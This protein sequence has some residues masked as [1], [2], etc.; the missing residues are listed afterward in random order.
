MEQCSAC[1]NKVPNLVEHLKKSK[2]C[3]EKVERDKVSSDF[4]RDKNGLPCIRKIIRDG[5]TIILK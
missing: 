3:A 2:K 5:E 1:K 4:K